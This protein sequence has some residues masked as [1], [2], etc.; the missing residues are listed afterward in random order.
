MFWV[1][2][3]PLEVGLSGM[4]KTIE[5]QAESPFGWQA[6]ATEAL[7][8]ASQTVRGIKSVRVDSFEAMFDGDHVVNY[9]IRA[10]V[11]FS[12]DS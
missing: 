1:L 5:V 12:L 11:C 9:R 6:A 10:L 4:E 8:A 3:V 2:K 7:T